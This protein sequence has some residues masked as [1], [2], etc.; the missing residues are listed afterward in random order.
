[1]YIVVSPCHHFSK[2]VNPRIEHVS[3]K[4]SELVQ[5]RCCCTICELKFV[6]L[7]VLRPKRPTMLIYTQQDYCLSLLFIFSLHPLRKVT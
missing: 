6:L 1:M 3:D 5:R 7:L 2:M 4:L